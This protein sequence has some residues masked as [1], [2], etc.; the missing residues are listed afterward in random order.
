MIDE[1][2]ALSPLCHCERPA[3][4]LLLLPPRELSL[5]QDTLFQ[6]TFPN[7]RRA[8]I[9]HLC[10]PHPFHSVSALEALVV[11]VSQI[12]L[13][14]LL[15]SPLHHPNSDLQSFALPFQLS[16]HFTLQAHITSF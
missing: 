4:H 15:S 5:S 8:L 11:L 12:E 2:V 14:T 6:L 10:R 1:A 3:F 9:F 16:F 7:S 13:P